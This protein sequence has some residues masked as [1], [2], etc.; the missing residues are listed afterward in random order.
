[1]VVKK[2]FLFLFILLVN[3]VISLVAYPVQFRRLILEKNGKIEK[4]VDFIFDAHKV[5]EQQVKHPLKSKQE[6]LLP[7]EKTML[8]NTERALIAD[9][10]I[11]SDKSKEKIGLL[12]ESGPLTAKL[13]AR[14][15]EKLNQKLH[16]MYYGI[17]TLRNEFSEKQN[18]KIIFI[19]ADT[20][21]EPGKGEIAALLNLP[22]DV[23]MYNEPVQKALQSLYQF[24]PPN[25]SPA[26]EDLAVAKTKV[27]EKTYKVLQLILENYKKVVM[28]GIWIVNQILNVNNK[29]AENTTIREFQQI[30]KQGNAFN[31]NFED[32][33][34]SK[35]VTE[36]MNVEL[37]FKIFVTPYKHLIIYAGAAHCKDVAQEL[38]DKF[39][40]KEVINVGLNFHFEDEKWL[41]LFAEYKIP[42]T[43][44]TWQLLA[45]D[46]VTSLNRFRT[47]GALKR[48]FSLQSIQELN[49]K[50]SMLSL[51]KIEQLIKD[52][53]AA[54]VDVTN[55]QS[56][57]DGKTLLHKAV[58]LKNYDLVALLLKYGANPNMKTN[59]GKAPIDI[60]N[61]DDLRIV[62]LL[63]QHG[64][65]LNPNLA[66][67]DGNTP[68]HF[69]AQEN[70]IP[71]I[72]LL[73]KYGGNPLIK[74][75]EGKSAI[76]YL[77]KSE[78]E[79]IIALYN[80]HK[81]MKEERKKLGEEKKAASSKQ[82]VK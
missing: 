29:T 42:L 32:F 63:L 26:E 1:M 74:N 69:A 72:E 19:D 77:P 10:R 18:K 5:I 24:L 28:G 7:A 34:F 45:E 52:G 82:E 64:A 53:Y 68:L 81:K 78:K 40:F 9:L 23:V 39:D 30:L 47:K 13:V 61:I 80:E 16:M 48:L 43:P 35:F 14:Q 33:F 41:K 71:F 66:D 27:D 21:R 55:T 36:M 65:T 58:K 3:S 20:Y 17:Y 44:N 12:W 11:L 75:K 51:P 62:E 22:A 57:E 59:K 4:V 73:I 15:H 50:L 37:V 76:D 8:T 38:L 6:Y 31:I 79:K 67:K 25:K 60:V 2:S 49:D 54:F 46:P 70:N 56:D